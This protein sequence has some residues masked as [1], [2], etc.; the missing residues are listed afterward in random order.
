MFA[1]ITFFCTCCTVTLCND[2]LTDFPVQHLR[3]FLILYIILNLFQLR[4]CLSGI[5]NSYIGNNY[6][7]LQMQLKVNSV[8]EILGILYLNAINWLISHLDFSFCE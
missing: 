7:S 2:V 5:K 4:Q 8:W 3:F 6:K 1:G